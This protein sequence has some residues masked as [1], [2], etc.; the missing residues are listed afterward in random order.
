[1]HRGGDVVPA[2]E[3]PGVREDDHAAGS[4]RG[5]QVPLAGALEARERPALAELGVLAPVELVDASLE[6][7]AI[8]AHRS[9]AGRNA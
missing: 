9:V 6:A 1:M 3:D 4:E 5:R 2:V 7:V 8:Q